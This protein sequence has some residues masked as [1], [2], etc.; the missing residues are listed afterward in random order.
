[1]G[2]LDKFVN[3]VFD[4]REKRPAADAPDAVDEPSPS[5]GE[6][7]AIEETPAAAA[8][9]QPEPVESA[10]AEDSSDAPSDPYGNFVGI[11]VGDDGEE[12]AVYDMEARSGMAVVYVDAER[13]A[14]EEGGSPDDASK[15]PEAAVAFREDGGVEPLGLDFPFEATGATGEMLGKW[16]LRL[17]YDHGMPSGDDEPIVE[18]YDGE[19]GEFVSDYWVSTF[20]DDSEE[21]EGQGLACK[22][23]VKRFR[24]AYDDLVAMQGRIRPFPAVAEWYS[25]HEGDMPDHSI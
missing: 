20:C 3:R 15:E 17:V 24:I 18:L 2:A 10:K 14:P 6:G 22:G 9:V 21:N 16:H 5:G 13:T 8:E 1:M 4:I 25:A 19:T 7:V 12:I 23:A 11:R